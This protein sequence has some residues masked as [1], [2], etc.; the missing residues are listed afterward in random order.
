[1]LSYSSR[2]SAFE[3]RH[4]LETD[5]QETGIDPLQ[6]ELVKNDDDGELQ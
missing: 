6:N 1:M 3:T 2:I 4:P 5:A